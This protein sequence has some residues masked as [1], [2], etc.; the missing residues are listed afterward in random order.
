MGVLIHDKKEITVPSVVGKN[1]YSAIKELSG[2]EFDIKKD[3]EEFDQNVPAGMILKQNPIAGINVRGRKLLKVITSLG[4]EYVNVPEIIGKNL[5][6]ADIIL[7]HSS[8]IIG[9]IFREYSTTTCKDVVISQDIAPTT[10]VDK[11]SIVNLIV[12]DGPPPE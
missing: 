12:S 5:R 7:K 1:F 3:G 10:M 4:K 8:L 9:E 11:Y 6:S 2:S